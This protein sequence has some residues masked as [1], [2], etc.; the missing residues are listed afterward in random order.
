MGSLSAGAE[1]EDSI[2]SSIYYV[3]GQTRPTLVSTDLQKLSNRSGTKGKGEWEMGEH[4]TTPWRGWVPLISPDPS[5][6]RKP[7]VA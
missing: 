1:D 7:F 3:Q 4:A 2:H 5:P 6:K